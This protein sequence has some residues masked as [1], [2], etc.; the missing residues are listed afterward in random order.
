VIQW[1]QEAY[2]VQKAYILSFGVYLPVGMS[3]AR[4]SC[5]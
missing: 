1:E 2:A 5:E 3:M 4:V